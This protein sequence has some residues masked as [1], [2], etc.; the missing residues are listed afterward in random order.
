MM[1]ISRA[2]AYAISAVLQLTES[3]AGEPVPCSRLAKMGAMPERFLLQVL[4]SLVNHG[5]LNSMRGVEGGYSLRC[6]ASEI[7]LLQI[8]EATD[9]PLVPVLPPLDI[10]PQRSQKRL[11]EVVDNITTNMSRKLSKITLE[12]LAASPEK[13][14]VAASAED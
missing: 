14:R 2:T 13:S 10:F 11:Q 7:T 12:D 5:L 3:P 4:R 6:K 9:G 1:K 8:I